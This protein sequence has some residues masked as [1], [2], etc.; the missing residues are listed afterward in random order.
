MGIGNV[1]GRGLVLTALMTMGP[2][3]ATA[4]KPMTFELVPDGSLFT[5][6]FASGDITAHTAAKFA[7]FLKSSGVKAPATVYLSSAGG[8]LMAGLALGRAIR[9]AGFG[10]E[11]GIPGQGGAGP[12]ACDSACTFSFLGGVTRTVS[13]GSLFGVHRFSGDSSDPLQEA[14]EIGGQLVAYMAEMDVS[15][16]LYTQ[17]TEGSPE[18]VKYLDAA[19]MAKLHVTTSETV[20]GR[21]NF[22]AGYPVLVVR[23][24]QGLVQYGRLDF[25][26]RQGQFIARGYFPERNGVVDASAMTL[27]WTFYMPGG[28]APDKVAV[29]PSAA[30]LAGTAGTQGTTEVGAAANP[31][32]MVDVSVPLSVLSGGIVKAQSVWLT[33]AAPGDP[34]VNDTIGLGTTQIPLPTKEMMQTLARGC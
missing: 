11:V 3:A 4:D 2:V 32:V 19:T 13:S 12:A 16:D 28:T 33:L 21:M 15:R 1:V 14:Q 24:L 25:F 6:I 34:A 29:P 27:S 9:A 7:S 30:M 17:M 23:D 10:T 8:D 20:R 18:Q 31:E 5:S 26:C 22:D